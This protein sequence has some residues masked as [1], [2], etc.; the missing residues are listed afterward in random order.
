MKRLLPVLLCLTASLPTFARPWGAVPIVVNPLGIELTSVNY[1]TT[2]FP[3]MNIMKM[4]GSNTLDS[5]WVTSTSNGGGDTSEEYSLNTDS[6]GYP[7]IIPQSG[8]TSTQV[9][10]LVYR[11][12]GGY[13]LAPGQSLYYPTG[14][15]T[16][17]FSGAGT[18]VISG[19]ASATITTSGSTFTVSSATTN[20]LFVNITSSTSGNHLTNL[21]IVQTSNVAAY[22]AGAIFAPSFLT[23]MANFKLLRM[24][25]WRNTN[26]QAYEAA[27]ASSGACSSGTQINSGATGLTLNQAWPYPT[28]TYNIYFG[29]LSNSAPQSE[30]K[31]AS[32]TYGSTTVSWTGGTSFNYL[33]YFP[34]DI[35]KSWANR[36]LPS[37]ASYTRSD[38]V[39]YEVQVAMCNAIGAN[40]WMNVPVN[41]SD[42]YIESWAQLVMSGTGAQ[43]GY[44]ALTSGLKFY[45]EF[46]N[47]VW[48]GAFPQNTIASTAGYVLWPS[49]TAAGGFEYNRSWYG[50]RVAQMATDIQTAVGST[51]FAN[52]IPVLGGQASF[53]A[54]ATLAIAA[55]DWPSGPVTSYPVKALSIAPY[56][57]GNPSS[58][59]ATTMTGVTT[60]LD[61][62]FATLYSQTGTV[63]NGSQ[64]YSSVPSGGWLGQIEGQI[65]SY[66]AIMPTYP[67]LSLV[68]YEGGQNFYA[69]SSG[70]ASGWPAL[71]ISAE[72]DAR[73]G[74]A[75]TTYLNYWKTNV[76]AT[77]TNINNIFSDV[78]P[79]TFNGAWGALESIM[80]TISPIGSAPAKWQAI[81]GYIQ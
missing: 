64:S 37:N 8:L 63:G 12:P 14:S 73:M 65:N 53:T 39:P 32:F 44:S 31:A 56:W 41:A 28:G 36:A 72:R 58:G 30:V 2:E 55:A 20:G 4:C 24:M 35:S 68:A 71:V 60:P 9:Y 1:F 40:C 10:C 42:A 43:S 6:D 26:A 23:A 27:C 79:I 69:T 38:G 51:L 3:F 59:D 75:Y 17:Q 77:S 76:G 62:F 22:N 52:C 48:N 21:S 46:S 67:T 47:E 57:G 78:G 34:V 18:V 74:T 15:Y 16:V 50:M 70:T 7:L 81:Q 66:T 29:T 80:Q 49:D 54:T 61:D 13:S 45:S 25:D 19:D 5:T 11:A 33:P